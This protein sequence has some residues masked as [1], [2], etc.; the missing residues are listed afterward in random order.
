M[1]EKRIEKR[2]IQINSKKIYAENINHPKL[3]NT[4][5][6]LSS[7]AKAVKGD[8][9]TIRSYINDKNKVNKLYRKQ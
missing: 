5:N 6:S 1:K 4:F 9:S 7:F 2:S 3:S 8:R